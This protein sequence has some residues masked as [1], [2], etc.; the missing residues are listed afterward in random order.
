M[1]VIC[2]ELVALRPV[3]GAKAD[4]LASNATTSNATTANISSN[5]VI[6]T[7]THAISNRR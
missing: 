4:T 2:N 3:A 6:V 7:V 1:L 5:E